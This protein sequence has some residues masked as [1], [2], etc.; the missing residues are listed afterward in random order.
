MNK[1]KIT[2]SQLSICGSK[3][4]AS[5]LGVALITGAPLYAAESKQKAQKPAVAAA[6]SKKPMRSYPALTELV[7]RMELSLGQSHLVRLPVGVNLQKVKVDDEK[8]VQVE[9]TSPREVVIHA[10]TVGSTVVIIWDKSGQTT[11]M[12]VSVVGVTVGVD[13]AALQAKLQQVLPSEKGIKVSTASDSIVLSGTV[14]DAVKVDKA[15]SLAEAY[16]GK[17]KDKKVINML[18]V[19]APQQVMLE[20]KMAEVSKNLLDKLGASFGASRTNGGVAYAIAAGFLSLTTSPFSGGAGGALRITHGNTAINIDAEDRDTVVKILAEPNIIA[21]SGQEGS[22]LAGGK[23][24]IPVPQGGSAAGAITLEEKDFG[25]GLKFTPT[26]LEDGLI[27]L[28]V[29]PEVT[30]LAKSEDVVGTTI[31]NSPFPSLVTRRVSTTVQ[32]RDG[33]SF[34]IAGL[35]KNNVTENIKRFPVLGNIP[36]LGALFRS[37]AFQNEKTELLFVVTPRLVKPLPPDYILPTD[38]FN[39][40]SKKEFFLDGKLEG[41]PAAPTALPSDATAPQSA[42]QGQ[43]DGFEV[44]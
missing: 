27:N 11:V 22:F 3:L 41:K 13:A 15:M 43:N 10:K 8:I 29:A 28:R 7:P 24:Y 35:L 14:A 5:M 9:V 40:P 4:L 25:V 1:H 20:V 33:Q 17:D 19:A 42:Q 39:A 6:V 32:L 26:V 16:V 37:S 34:A 31:A 30:E 18:Q 36:I 38:S 12:D 21:I 44:K 23:F 2:N